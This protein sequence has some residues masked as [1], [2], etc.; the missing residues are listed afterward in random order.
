M[1]VPDRISQ[2]HDVLA[3]LLVTLIAAV[4]RARYLSSPPDLVFDE[5]YASDAC[6]YFGGPASTCH[7]AQEITIVH[8]PL[9]KWLIGIGVWALGFREVGWRIASAVAG[10]LTVA[11][12]YLLARTLL[13]STLAATVASGLLAID[14]LHI[15]FSRT[16]MLDVFVTFF[17]V[18]AFLFLAMH[19][20]VLIESRDGGVAASRW[21]WLALAGIAA[22]AAGASKWSAWPCLVAMLFLALA[23]EIELSRRDGP[24]AMS[25]L[26]I[27]GDTAAPIVLCLVVMPLLVYALSFAGRLD[28]RLLA[29]PWAEDAWIRAFV[30]RQAFMARFHRTLSGSHPFTSPAWSWLLLKRPVLMYYRET[31][32]GLYQVVL[33]FGSPLVWWS[34]I[35]ALLYLTVDFLRRRSFLN[36]TSVILAGFAACYVPWLLLGHGRQQV[37]NYYVLPAVPFMCLALGA[38]ASRCR[39]GL[40][41]AVT[42]AAFLVCASTLLLF[43]RP[44]LV[45]RPLTPAEWR[46]RML[47][48]DCDTPAGAPLRPQTIPGPPPRGWCWP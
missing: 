7:T 2:R 20:D 6:L 44:I 39:R 43:Y 8:P 21:R 24:P 30:E 5:F 46:A 19:R 29:W 1:I 25:I 34:S 31:R 11:A 37:F 18:I 36:P 22:G 42:I 23:W 45:G 12:L 15:V 14:F 32:D 28:G 40:M 38:V 26:R 35:A 47:F 41:G 33:A 48:R 10:T 13:R 17:V 9:A 27:L 4:I 16:A 3:L